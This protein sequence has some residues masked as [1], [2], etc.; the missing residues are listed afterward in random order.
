MKRQIRLNVFETNS[1]STHS[2][3][4]CTEQDFKEWEAGEKLFDT[5]TN[6]M[7]NPTK[8]NKC[9]KKQAINDYITKQAKE[10]FWCKWEDLPEVS[11]EAWFNNWAVINILNDRDDFCK[12][13]L[14]HDEYYDEHSSMSSFYEHFVTPSGDKMVAFGYYGYD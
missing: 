14:T 11:K 1:S 7:I 8:L 5:G 6:E 3:V 12:R 4:I 9:Q 13:Y 2:L 10:K